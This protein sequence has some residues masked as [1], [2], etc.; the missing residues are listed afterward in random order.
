[1]FPV[2]ITEIQGLEDETQVV[3]DH[4]NRLSCIVCKIFQCLK[5]SKIKCE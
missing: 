3:V 1:M 4:L 2:A 5:G